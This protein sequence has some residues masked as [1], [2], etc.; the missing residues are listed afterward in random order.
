MD[1]CPPRFPEKKLLL[2]T[3]PLT[4]PSQLCTRSLER[5]NSCR[6]STTVSLKEYTVS[7]WKGKCLFNDPFTVLCQHYQLCVEP[8]WTIGNRVYI[9]ERQRLGPQQNYNKTHRP[10]YRSREQTIKKLLNNTM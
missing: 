3:V 1:S 2:L 9:G 10:E 6:V 8:A 4:V 5:V 7:I